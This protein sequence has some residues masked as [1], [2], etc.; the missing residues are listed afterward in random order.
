MS[1]RLSAPKHQCVFVILTFVVSFSYLSNI[2]YA[3]DSSAINE[4]ELKQIQDWQKIATELEKNGDFTEAHTTYEKIIQAYSKTSYGLDACTKDARL[5]V[6]QNY[7]DNLIPSVE[8]ICT[9]YKEQQYAAHAVSDIARDCMFSKF[10]SKAIE[11]CQKGIEQLYEHPRKL[12][13]YGTLGM[14]YATEGDI[15]NAEQIKQLILHQEECIASDFLKAI[16]DIGWGYYCSGELDRAIATYRQGL[17]LNSTHIGAIHLQYQIVRAYVTRGDLVSADREMD[18]LLAE[19]SQR[20]QTPWLA[21]RLASRDYKKQDLE[22]TINVY[23]KLLVQFAGHSIVPSI[24]DAI[25]S[26]Y[27]DAGDLAKAREA[28]QVDIE[29][30]PYRSELLRV[31]TRIAVDTARAGDT[32]I[33]MELVETIFNQNPEGADQLLF[34]YTTLARV[35]AYQG[36]DTDV[37]ATYKEALELFKDHPDSLSYHL[38]GV[39][40]EYY[41]MAQKAVQNQETAQATRYYQQAIDKWNSIDFDRLP[42]RKAIDGYYSLGDCYRKTGN[43]KESNYYFKKVVAQS[44]DQALASKALLVVAKNFRDMGNTSQIQSLSPVDPNSIVVADVSVCVDPNGT[45]ASG[46]VFGD[47]NRCCKLNINSETDAYKYLADNYPETQAGEFARHF[48]NRRK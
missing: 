2:L 25:V 33:A 45:I 4:V 42:S 5:Y 48:L 43:Y 44:G 12:L 20:E 30:C 21:L 16:G 37:T 10:Y 26:A 14:I 47:N 3:A 11:I 23:D 24:R 34:G 18:V 19:Y 9:D 32:E 40:E 38:F 7:F 13:L 27:A 46:L 17:E 41:L 35:Y 28:L 1:K 15:E 29:Q 6:K 8:Q 39:G 22:S 31:I 36:K